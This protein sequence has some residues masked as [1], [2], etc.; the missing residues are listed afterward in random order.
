M[1]KFKKYFF[2]YMCSK[3]FGLQREVC[4]AF[5]QQPLHPGI[6]P[7][8]G[9]SLLSVVRPWT[10]RWFVLRRRTSEWDWP[11]HVTT[12]HVSDQKAEALGLI[13]LAQPPERRRL[14]ME[15]KLLATKR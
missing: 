2:L 15:F 1:Q 6:S 8:V 7:V 4:M 5:V 11:H 9:V 14:E 13:L 10:N 12:N 3:E